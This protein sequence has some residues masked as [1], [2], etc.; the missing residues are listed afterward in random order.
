VSPIQLGRYVVACAA[1]YE[2]GFGVPS[3]RFLRLLLQF[4]GLELHHL[5]PS[6]IL[7]MAAFVTL[8]EDY[9][10]IEPHFN[11]WNYF[12]CGR[13]HQGSGAEAMVLG[14]VRPSGQKAEVRFFLRNDADAPLPMFMGSRPAPDPTGGYNVAQKDLRRIQPLREVVQ[15]L[16]QGELTGADLLRTF[17]SHRV[18]PL[19]RREMTLWM[20]PGLSCP[21]H[22]FSTQLGD[23]EINT[24]IRGVLA[25]GADLAPTQSL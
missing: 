7:Q 4:Y 11:L 14:N 6:R 15:Q 20:Y 1:F 5:T 17:F 2:W 3:H 19:R 12:C 16:L 24:W 25:R 22:P 18:Q 13:L 21:D 8:C 23:T 10:W 9:M